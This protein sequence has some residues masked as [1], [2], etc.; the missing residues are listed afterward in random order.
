[1]KYSLG[2]VAG[3]SCVFSVM[4][5]NSMVAVITAIKWSKRHSRGQPHSFT[6]TSMLVHGLT[7]IVAVSEVT[8]CGVCVC[9]QSV[10]LK[11]I[12][13]T[14]VKTHRCMDPLHTPGPAGGYTF[15]YKL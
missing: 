7:L 15:A 11:E 2:S 1:M 13:V 4:G 14:A 10:V 6:S 8:L 5:L 12:I 9:I 3:E